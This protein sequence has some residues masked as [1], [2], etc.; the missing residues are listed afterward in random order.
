MSVV[1]LDNGRLYKNADSSV[2]SAFT[3]VWLLTNGNYSNCFQ[4][5]MSSFLICKIAHI[6]TRDI[7]VIMAW[8]IIWELSGEEPISENFPFIINQRIR[9]DTKHIAATMQ[10][11]QNPFFFQFNI[12]PLPIIIPMQA[13]IPITSIRRKQVW[14][15]WYGDKSIEKGNDWICWTMLV[16]PNC[17]RD[18]ITVIALAMMPNHNQNVTK[19]WR[20]FCWFVFV[21]SSDIL[22]S[23]IRVGH[24][25]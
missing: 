4:Q 17:N 5:L 20:F 15:V 7:G 9:V 10:F 22:I 8:V 14:I 16:L 2:L 1:S 13:N 12:I 19:P 21:I 3:R 18:L 25:F 23:L 24:N 6:I 11:N